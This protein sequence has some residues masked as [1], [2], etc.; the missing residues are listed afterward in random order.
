LRDDVWYVDH[1]SLGLDLQI[2]WRTVRVVLGAE[3]ITAE[4]DA[5]MPP[6]MG[7]AEPAA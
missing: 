1:A 3:G 7:T 6:F 2:L 4:G 5:T